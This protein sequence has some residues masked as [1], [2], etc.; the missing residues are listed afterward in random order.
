MTRL[1]ISD[2]GGRGDADAGGWADRNP[3]ISPLNTILVNFTFV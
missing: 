1:I 2:F 3:G